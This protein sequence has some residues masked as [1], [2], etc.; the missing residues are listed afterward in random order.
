M[1]A[2]GCRRPDLVT[3]VTEYI[4]E[5]VAYCQ[6]IAENGLAYAAGG[7]LY[8]DTAAFRWAAC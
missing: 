3:R 1:D 7:S 5:I 6:R 4:P 2:L 8:F